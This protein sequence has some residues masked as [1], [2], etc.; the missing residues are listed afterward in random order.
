MKRRIAPVECLVPCEVD[1]TH[2]AA[3]VQLTG[4]P[5]GTVPAVG[6]REFLPVA[7]GAGTLPVQRKACVI[8]EKTPQAHLCSRQGVI[9]GDDGRRKTLR[10]AMHSTGK[11]RR[12]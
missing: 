9:R 10:Y 2:R 7:G 8:E 6:E 3:R 11:I 1:E 5:F 4:G 12:R